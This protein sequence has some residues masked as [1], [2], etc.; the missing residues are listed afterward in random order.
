MTATTSE[1]AVAPIAVADRAAAD[2]EAEYRRRGWWRDQ[3]FLDDLRRQAR[4]RPHQLAIAGQ[5]A[6]EVHTDT[7]DYAGLAGLS[8]RFAG[9]LLDLGVKPGDVVVVQLPNRWELVPLLYACLRVGAVICPIAPECRAEDLRYRFAETGA[10]VCIIVPVWDGYPLAETVIALR[11]E[12]GLE[13]V[14]VL[15]GPAGADSLDFHETFVARSGRRPDELGDAVELGPDDPFVVLFTSGTT[16]RPKGVL[17]SQNTVYAALSGY[18]DALKSDDG[19]VIASTTPLVHY[20]GFGQAILAAAMAGGTVLFQ[21]TRHHPGLLDLMER[22][23]ATLLYGPPT[24]L[25]GVAAAQRAEPRDL[26]CLR[27]V[28]A[29]SAPVVQSLVDDVRASLGACTYSL[30]GM[31]EFGP[32]TVSRLDDDPDWAA[33]SHGRPID[34]MEI[35]VDDREHPGR[36]AP[37]GR[38]RVRGASRALG[39]L[40]AQDAFTAAISADGWFDTGDLAREDGRGGIRILSRARD[41]VVRDG[42][43]VPLAE[44]EA[45]LARHPAVAEA[46]LLGVTGRED[47]PILAVVVVRGTTAPTLPELREHLLAGGVDRRFLP[48][49]LDVVDALPK[50][51]TGKVRKAELRHG[52]DADPDPH[53]SPR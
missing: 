33:R 38:V 13:H 3:T 29:G 22:H 9:A 51:L 21:E 40:G 34:A 1:N 27:Q 39:Y 5:R 18:L 45:A 2:F 17:H 15:G 52:P 30:W 32:I 11:E 41:A 24:T 48:D 26:S 23:R 10:K 35:R 14:V 25:A 6:G 53:R 4:D 28:I 16:N 50:T 7:L 19:L 46:T 42:E 47:D 43:V 12:F 44:I 49:L 36:P 20:S 31:S 37:V 8:E